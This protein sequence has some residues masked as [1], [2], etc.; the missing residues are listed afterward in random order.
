MSNLVRLPNPRRVEEQAAEWVVC[1]QEGLTEEQRKGLHEWLEAD[2]GHSEALVRMA[3]LWDA[4]DA[5]AELA[6]T[7]PL[8]QRAAE[9]PKTWT[10]KV[11]AFAALAVLAIGVSITMYL[12]W[13]SAGHA[14][15]TPEVSAR[16]V[17]PAR[18]E[19]P[20][21]ATASEFSAHNYHTPV[22]SQ[23][24]APLSDGSVITLN[25]DTSV[26]VEYTASQRLIVLR[27]G[28]ANF[29]VAHDA[30]RPFQVQVGARVVQALGTVFNVKLGTGKDVRVSVSEGTVK[31]LDRPPSQPTRAAPAPAHTE[32]LVRA[33]DQATIGDDGE[34]VRHIGVSQIEAN[35]AWQHGMLVYKGET[36]ATV[37]ADVSRYTTVRFSI[38]DDSIRS[39]RVGGVFR[40]GDVDG[41]LVALRESFGIDARREGNVIVLTAKR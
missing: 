32:L 20:S 9:R 21:A 11:V 10:L 4:F 12:R 23:L 36:L 31:V 15:G 16:R 38:S 27:K 6:E 34:Q 33:G 26:D 7:F 3:E 17:E 1:L 8:T 14:P 37:I 30:T 28:E 35:S 41:L 13:G 5:L 19:A 24:A 25:T 29:N 22:G 39:K 18:P 40:A 2:P